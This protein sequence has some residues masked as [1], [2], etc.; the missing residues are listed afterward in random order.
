MRLT[1]AV[2]GTPHRCVGGCCC[3]DGGN[4]LA[5]SRTCRRIVPFVV[6]GGFYNFFVKYYS[7]F[8]LVRG[9]WDFEDMEYRRWTNLRVSKVRLPPVPSIDHHMLTTLIKEHLMV[10]NVK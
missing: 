7:S 5:E 4:G 1:E 6:L 3:V 2:R 10:V 9:Q 8:D